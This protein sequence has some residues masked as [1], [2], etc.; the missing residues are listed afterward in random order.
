M[1][2]QASIY[3]PRGVSLIKKTTVF[4]L[5][6][7]NINLLEYEKHNPTNEFLDSLSSNMFLP[8]ILLPTRISSNSKTLIDDIF[9]KFIS[10]EVIAGNLTATISNHLPQF[11]I[12]PDIFCNPPPNKNSIFEKNWS[13]FNHENFILDYFDINW[14]N[15]LKLEMQNVDL[16]FI[17]FYEAINAVLD[18]HVPYQKVKKYAFSK[19]T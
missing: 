2:L 4:L 8:Y 11:L 3:E 12:A 16:S 19:T 14:P 9:S 7:F 15:V 17:N 10:N 6:D 1:H 18:K 5:G 13:K